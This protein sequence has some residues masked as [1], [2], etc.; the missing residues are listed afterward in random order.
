M[1]TAL[2][3]VAPGRVCNGILTPWNREERLLW[4]YHEQR[5]DMMSVCVKAA[6]RLQRPLLVMT[7]KNQ[8]RHGDPSKVAGSSSAVT[9]ATHPFFIPTMTVLHE[10]SALV[11]GEGTAET[12]GD[13]VRRLGGHADTVPC[14]WLVEPLC[15]LLLRRPLA[16][17]ALVPLW[18]QEL[19]GCREAFT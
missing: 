17:L 2:V 8:R 10:T 5:L 13:I 14:A 7:A 6:W 16:C 15:Q 19:V 11:N 3:A 18:A 12:F 1:T 9:A 4:D